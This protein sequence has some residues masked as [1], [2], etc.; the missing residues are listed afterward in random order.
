MSW[1]W[2]EKSGKDDNFVA[3]SSGIA[4]SEAHSRSDDEAAQ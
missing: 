4:L 3:V 2:K 1:T